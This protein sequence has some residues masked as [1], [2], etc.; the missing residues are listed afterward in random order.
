MI[1]VKYAYLVHI[2]EL[3]SLQGSKGDQ[4]RNKDEDDGNWREIAEV[5]EVGTF[6]AEISSMPSRLTAGW[7]DILQLALKCTGT[8][9][10]DT[11]T[12]TDDPCVEPLPGYKSKALLVYCGIYPADRAKYPD[13]RD[14]LEKLH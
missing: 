9:V 6:R 11:I 10:G 14:A 3:S 4:S 12:D 7:L 1:F 5:V 13:L 2:K 8:R